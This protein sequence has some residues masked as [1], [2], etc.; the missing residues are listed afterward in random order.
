MS[1]KLNAEALAAS[2]RA[3]WATRGHTARV[4]V[5]QER[6]NASPTDKRLIWV[7]RSALVGGMPPRL[8]IKTA[9]GVQ[10]D[11]ASPFSDRPRVGQRP[12]P[13]ESVRLSKGAWR[14]FDRRAA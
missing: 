12:I 7:V 13:G 8:G 1:N 10:R 6:A 9:S 2:I 14:A 3:H 11:S 5:Q 4:W